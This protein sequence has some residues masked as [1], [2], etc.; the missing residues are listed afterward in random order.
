MAW[1]PSA[2]HLESAADL[3]GLV[4]PAFISSRRLVKDTHPVKLH[5][6]WHDAAHILH[7]GLV[8]RGR[9]YLPPLLADEAIEPIPPHYKSEWLSVDLAQSLRFAPGST[10]FRFRC[11]ELL[12]DPYRV[13]VTLN[14]AH[15]HPAETG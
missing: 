4:I 1:V 13:I 7:E 8:D 9:D 11:D 10:T 2:V 14:P 15:E 5:V 6:Q 12:S 3:P